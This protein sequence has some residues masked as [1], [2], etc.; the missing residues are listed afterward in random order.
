MIKLFVGVPGAGKSLAMQDTVRLLNRE[1]KLGCVVIDR[2]NEWAILDK[3]GLQN[4]RWRGDPPSLT[5]L[6]G[7]DS[8]GSIREALEGARDNGRTVVFQQ[9]EPAVVGDWVR[10]IGYLVYCDDEIDLTAR[11][12]G[13]HEN[14][15]RAFVHTGR[16]LPNED[17]YP[18]EVHILGACRRV[19]NIHTDLTELADE[20]FVF[21]SQGKNTIK[22][23]L[24]EG[25]CDD[26]HVYKIQTQPN[27]SY[28]R[29]RNDGSMT[30][31]HLLPLTTKKGTHES[32]PEESRPTE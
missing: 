23:I 27:L 7:G 8:E 20:V 1:S 28:H 31:G 10:R 15:L 3:D 32:P 13:W 26:A 21:R 17:G 2:T 9:T 5:L 16:H 11:V 6:T 18:S 22:R 25:W 4:V 19:Q 14:P 29:W 12:K 30:E 24:D